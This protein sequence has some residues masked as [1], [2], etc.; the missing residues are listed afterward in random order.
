MLDIF[1]LE[2]QREHKRLASFGPLNQ[3]EI[4]VTG[5]HTIAPGSLEF[6][7]GLVEVCGFQF[8]KRVIRQLGDD[9]SCL[10]KFAPHYRQ[11]RKVDAANPSTLP[12]AEVNA[13]VDG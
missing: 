6:P 5:D 2:I 10:G 3:A 12:P 11:R 8:H 9:G 4:G 13:H 1:F 7:S